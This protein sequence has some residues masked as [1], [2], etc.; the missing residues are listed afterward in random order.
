MSKYE[1]DNE[2]LV[3]FLKTPRADWATCRWVNV[4]G[5]SWDVIKSLGNEHNLH[6]LA[7]EDLMN[8]RSR[9]KADWYSDHAF[10]K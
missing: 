1:L 8:T 5:L 6:R 2:G 9:T 7:I 10:S 4:N 3:E